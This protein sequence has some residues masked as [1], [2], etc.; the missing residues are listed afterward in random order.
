MT[1][2]RTA[3][4]EVVLAIA[5]GRMSKDELVSFI[6]NYVEATSIENVDL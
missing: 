3:F 6:R 5:E 1:T 4:E 2:D